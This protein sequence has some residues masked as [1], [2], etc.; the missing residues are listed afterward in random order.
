[1]SDNE[2]CASLR[3]SIYNSTD[4]EMKTVEIKNENVQRH[5]TTN[6]KRDKKYRI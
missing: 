3:I 6:E 1:M 2:S 5:L 4:I